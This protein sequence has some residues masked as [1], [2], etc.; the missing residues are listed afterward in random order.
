[1]HRPRILGP[2]VRANTYGWL[3]GFVFIIVATILADVVGLSGAEFYL[4]VGMAGGV[5]LLQ[6]RAMKRLL[7]LTGKWGW[8]VFVGISIP[9]LVF[10]VF[11]LFLPEFGNWVLIAVKCAIGGLLA[12]F[13]QV[14]ML[15][16]LVGNVRWWPYVSALGWGLAATTL[17]LTDA[18]SG[19]SDGAA[20]NPLIEMIVFLGFIFAGGPII[21]LV[22]GVFLKRNL[23]AARQAE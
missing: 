13:A 8:A 16:P 17:G 9:F 5:G 19:S 3:V 18:F 12:G 14:K 23:I 10:D 22:T 11:G 4:G 6:G 7:G 21:G 20:D 1:M 2:W 15:R